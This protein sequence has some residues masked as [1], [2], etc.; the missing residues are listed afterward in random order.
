MSDFRFVDVAML[1]AL[2]LLAALAAL[3]LYASRRRRRDLR[4]FVEAGLLE[5][6]GPSS[7]PDPARRVLKAALALAAAGALVVALARPAWDEQQDEVTQRGRDVVFLLD[8][9]RSMLAEDLPPNRLQRA[10]LA[11]LDAV[12][13]LDGD[14]VALAVFAG[15]AVVKCPLTLD[16]GFFRMALDDVT[17]YSVE[18]GGTLIGDALRTVMRDVF[19][20]KS[21]NYRDI[22]LITDGEDHESFPEEAAAEAGALGARLIAIGLGDERV[23]RRIP[24][25]AEGSGG[26]SAGDSR[27]FLQHEGREVWSRLDAATLRRMADAT[28]GGIYLNVATGAIDLGDVYRRLIAS[29]ESGEVG[30]VQ[31]E[32]LEERFQLF[33]AICVLLLA[34][35]IGLRERRGLARTAASVLALAALAPSG[36]QAAT[37][38]GLVNEGNDA[39]RAEAYDE[40]LLAYDQALAKEP[41]SPYAVLNRANALY[42]SGKYAEAVEGFSEAVRRSLDRDLPF[43]EAVGL[44]NLGNALFRQAEEAAPND[45][46][47]AI[48]LLAPAARSFLDA[49]RADSRRTDSARNLELARRLSAQLREDLREQAGGQD[50]SDGDQDADR[51]EDGEENRGESLQQAAR[52]QR[53]LADE[54]EQL[55]KDRQ[56]QRGSDAREEQRQRAQDLADRQED[57]RERTRELGKDAD[58]QARQSVEQAG[59]DQDRAREDLER[60]R[61]EDASEA[62]HRAAEALEEAARAQGGGDGERQEQAA[63]PDQLQG[64]GDRPGEDAQQQDRD[65]AMD[66][67]LSKEKQDRRRRQL[68]QR[69]GAVAVDRDW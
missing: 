14:R 55:A 58:P 45:P 47:Q 10:K 25:V 44:H 20:G 34:L 57:L 51:P 30:S 21:S 69:V 11:I 39:V 17:T 38:R 65:M 16:Y 62:Q 5:R 68:M 1:N 31:V 67:I 61:P 60:N 43:L 4:R 33:L 13:R 36:A 48:E 40:A 35:E 2:W 3:M 9:S 50:G 29:A 8:V 24:V 52:E 64:D 63:R 53:Q 6:L 59:G 15:S 46:R 12:D 42:R 56:Q 23:G 19:D 26:Q 41:E 18:R 28:P 54:S 66:Q 32:R 7:S 37:V 49:L 27:R 22:V